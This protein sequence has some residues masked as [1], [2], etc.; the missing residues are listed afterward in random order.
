MSERDVAVIA[1]RP[2]A[3]RHAAA[4]SPALLSQGSCALLTPLPGTREATLDVQRM[5][6][7]GVALGRP[8]SSA[9][10]QTTRKEVP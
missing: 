7:A 10:P 3:V 5:P 4:N 9:Q 1:A 8:S 2:T 6:S